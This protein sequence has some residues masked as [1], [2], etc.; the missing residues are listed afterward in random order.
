MKGYLQLKSVYGRE[1][2]RLQRVS[3][4]IQVISGRWE[5]D[6]ER[7]FAMEPFLRSGRFRP[8]ISRTR[9]LQEARVKQIQIS[10]ILHVGQA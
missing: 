9:F 6:N 5:G 7:L 4:P 10:R 2:F 8:P 1:D 3:K